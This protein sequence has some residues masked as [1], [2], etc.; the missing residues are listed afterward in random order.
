MS[1][2]DSMI[3]RAAKVLL[4]SL[5]LGLLVQFPA[6][7]MPRIQHWETANGARV[8]FVPA[9]E[10]P[11]V[12]INVT[13]AAGSARDAG[14]AGLSHLTSDLLDSGA[15]GLSADQ[16]AS[17]VEAL[18]AVLDTGAARDMAWVS[19][20][21]LSD[22]EHL[23]PALAIFADVLGQPDFNAS[24]LDRERARTLVGLRSED[25]SPSSVAENAIFA[26]IY[27]KHPYAARESG[28]PESVRKITRR[29]IVDFYRRYYVAHNAIIAMVGNLDR[30]AAEQVAEQVA[31]KLQPGSRAPALPVPAALTH[32]TEQRIAHSSAQTTVLVGQPGMRRGDPDYFPLYVGNHILG[33]GGLV[34]RLSDEIR[35]KRGLS[36]SV[37]SYFSP[38]EQDG[39]FL[40]SLQTRNDQTDEALGL[41]R[42]TLRKFLQEGPT[43]KELEDAKKNLTGGFPLRIDS[44]SKILDYLVMIGFYGLPLDYL[45]TFSANVTAVTRAQILDAFHRRVHPDTMATVIVG[46]KP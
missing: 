7:A 35:E 37:S 44:N 18:G 1:Y 13:F 21:S 39:P 40:L 2:A 26:A 23:Q 32:A 6:Q 34:S 8:Y 16:I 19:L 31:A 3:R 9:P 38:M 4:A 14:N 33:G 27:G 25:Q 46:G 17:R 22:A 20:R 12:D 29:Q 28:T 11:M 41:L 30:K 5:V 42:D 15:A 36:Y 43:A 10:L 45:D 24:D